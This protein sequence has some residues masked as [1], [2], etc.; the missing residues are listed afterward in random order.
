[1]RLPKKEAFTV[2]L[3]VE[4]EKAINVVALE[5]FLDIHFL[6]PN[7]PFFFFFTTSS[8]SIAGNRA[9][10]LVPKSG[11]EQQEFPFTKPWAKII[12]LA[13]AFPFHRVRPAR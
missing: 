12:T 7:L 4:G 8:S 6:H 9:F 13:G 10:N 5:L 1:M 3:R 11:R 2:W